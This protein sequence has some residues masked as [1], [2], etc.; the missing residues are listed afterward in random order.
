MN[1]ILFI[2]IF[3]HNMPHA[4]SDIHNSTAFYILEGI[5]RPHCSFLQKYEFK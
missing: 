1:E 5:S 3:Q 4:L 2:V